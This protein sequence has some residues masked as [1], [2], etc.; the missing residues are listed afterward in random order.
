[1]KSLG[2]IVE[3]YEARSKAMQSDFDRMNRFVNYMSGKDPVAVPELDRNEQSAIANLAAQGLEQLSLRVASTLPMPR[4]PA[5]RENIKDSQQKARK[6]LQANLGWWE[7]N[8]MQ[9][10]LRIRAEHYLGLG[11]APVSVLPSPETGIPEWRV[12]NPQHTLPAPNADPKAVE[13]DWCIFAYQQSWGWVRKRYPTAV[14]P[15]CQDWKPDHPVTIIEYVDCEQ[16][17]YAAITGR[18]APVEYQSWQIPTIGERGAAL[19][20]NIPNKAGCPLVFVPTLYG[21]AGVHGRF[22]GTQGAHQ[23]RA[24]FLALAY[25][26]ASKG[27]APDPW[28]EPFD[29]N[30]DP[31]VL[32]PPDPKEGTP[33][34][35]RGGKLTWAAPQ[36]GFMTS[37]ML[38][39]LER[40]IRSEGG[41]PAEF[42]GEA[43]STVRTG[44]RGGQI[45][46]STID[47]PIQDA[48]NRFAR[49]LTA[50][51]KAAVAIVKNWTKGPRSFYVNWKGARGQ[52]DYDPASDFET[53]N[54]VVEYPLAGSDLN[55]DLLRIQQK[56]ATGM[57]PKKLA[58]QMDPETPDAEQAH[59]W[60]IAE[61]LEDA[62]VQ[63]LA[64]QAAAGQLPPADLARIMTLVASDKLELAEAVEQVQKEAQERQA[65]QVA[66]TAPEAQP[67]IAQPG[68][69]AE[70]SAIPQGPPA[71]SNLSA[72]LSQ[73]GASSPVAA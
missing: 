24:K 9:G 70:S 6:R 35:V 68:M 43:T 32:S 51:N 39:I 55:N 49:S 10:I 56:V 29:A 16:I 47:F 12:R 42:G 15:N 57:W 17:T 67:G 4:W 2:E 40:E 19:L 61:Q 8:D 73:L 69:G 1:M 48:Q 38:G 13:R 64:Q 62:L 59:D 31:E 11:L 66:A 28:L 20:E 50:E 33:G 21:L 60:V 5:L 54:N 53:D 22:E 27:A 72:A 36:P 63:S 23:M 34:I 3:L 18:P 37:P 46:A 30:T 25:I 58:R 65:A 44:R 52:V 7:F 26:T 71:L 45:I 41:I 14:L